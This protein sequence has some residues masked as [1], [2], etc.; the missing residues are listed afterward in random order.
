[1]R[2]S[3]SGYRGVKRREFVTGAAAATTLYGMPRH[4]MAQG[5]QMEFD[6]SKFQL[7]APEPNPK[8]G[9]VLK[10]GITMRPPH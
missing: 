2:E 4:T 6:G 9:G 3:K 8:K 7:A 10:Y 1:M 5:V